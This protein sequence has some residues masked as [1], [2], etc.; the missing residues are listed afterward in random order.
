MQRVPGTGRVLEWRLLTGSDFAGLDPAECVVG[1]TFSPLEVHGP[2]LPVVTDSAEGDEILRRS[3]ERLES[4]FPGKT[5][6]VLPPVFVAADVLPHRG[7]LMFRPST[8]ER[9]AE[10]LGRSLAKQGFKDIIVSN[11]HGG[12]RHFVPIERAC[13]RV[14]RR[15]GAR[16]VCAFSLLITRLTQGATDLPGVLGHLPGLD[17]ALLE[18]DAHGGLVETS[19]MLHLFGDRV[20]PQYRTLP[21]RT[22]AAW[23]AEHGGPPMGRKGV[24]GVVRDLV[25]KM[26]YYEDET[27][28]GAPSTASAA[29]GDAIFDVLADHSSKALAELLRGELRP[30]DCHS[31]LYKLDWL[32]S[33]EWISRVVE[34][35][36]GYRQRVF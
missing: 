35:A 10:D 21:R 16:M 36:A 5:F 22:V 18:G 12:P 23:V 25:R 32:F 29:T 2:H 11:F 31:P 30:E 6:L 15:Y 28:T 13:A 34:R 14:N 7:S 27:Y 4:Q 20:D 1:V 9:V 17:R 19:M 3:F 24:I 8:I 26:K 33:S